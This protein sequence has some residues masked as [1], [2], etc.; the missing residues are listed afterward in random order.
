MWSEWQRRFVERERAAVVAQEQERA[1]WAGLPMRQDPALARQVTE[2]LLEPWAALR[3]TFDLAAT[4]AELPA[5]VHAD[6]LAYLSLRVD[7][8]Q[9]V[10]RRCLNPTAQTC[11][12]LSEYERRIDVFIAARKRASGGGPIPPS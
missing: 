3:Q 12:Q 9:A 11:A 6:Y 8:Y 4:T 1:M 5:A 2:R 10:V 7:Y